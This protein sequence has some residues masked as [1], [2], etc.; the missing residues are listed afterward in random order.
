MEV[1]WQDEGVQMCVCVCVAMGPYTETSELF[2][3][4][5]LSSF[6]ILY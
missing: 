4:T 1:K 2:L 5:D 6:L 3:W